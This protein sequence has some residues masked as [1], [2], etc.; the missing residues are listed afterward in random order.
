MIISRVK[1]NR[2]I[3]ILRDNCV[4]GARKIELE[5]MLEDGEEETVLIHP[6][7][8]RYYRNQVSALSEALSDK[9]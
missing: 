6:E 4:S 5:A 3:L 9:D 7:M 8:G 2:N 1:K